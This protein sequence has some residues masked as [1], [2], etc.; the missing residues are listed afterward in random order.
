MHTCMHA[1]ES[2]LCGLRG[3]RHKGL[4]APSRASGAIGASTI[5]DCA[6]YM[7][8]T[9][10]ENLSDLGTHSKSPTKSCPPR[11]W[12]PLA[13]PSTWSSLAPVPPGG[14]RKAP[15]RLRSELGQDL[16]WAMISLA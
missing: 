3:T 10:S 12:L 13:A 11:G 16:S 7:G 15:W 1:Y 9:Q 6:S 4:Y 5:G 8:H 14:F 2:K